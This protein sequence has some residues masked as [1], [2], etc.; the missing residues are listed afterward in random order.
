[1]KGEIIDLKLGNCPAC[2][3]PIAEVVKIKRICGEL[4]QKSGTFPFHH[5][6]KSKG[7]VCTKCRI[8]FDFPPV[9][10]FNEP[11]RLEKLAYQ[12][13]AEKTSYFLLKDQY[14]HGGTDGPT[15]AL[16]KG[17]IVY[18]VPELKG[19][20]KSSINE[21]PAKTIKV[22]KKPVPGEMMV[23]A[24]VAELSKR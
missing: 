3:S 22:T 16:K 5:E 6:I 14:F 24:N 17:I 11:E 18:L 8:K 23:E 19:R 13:L 9:Y 21:L 20:S 15:L 2:K 4:D 7:H 12:V 10:H 1:M